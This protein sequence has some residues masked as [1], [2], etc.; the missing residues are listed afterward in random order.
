MNLKPTTEPDVRM[1]NSY[2]RCNVFFFYSQTVLWVRFRKIRLE[3]RFEQQGSL[4]DRLISKWR[5]ASEIVY[6]ITSKKKPCLF[7]EKNGTRTSMCIDWYTAHGVLDDLAVQYTEQTVRAVRRRDVHNARRAVEREQDF[8]PRGTRYRY[9]PGTDG[10]VT[11]FDR[12]AQGAVGRVP[13]VRI[14]VPCVHVD[15]VPGHHLSRVQ[16]VRRRDAYRRAF[17]SVGFRVPFAGG[18]PAARGFAHVPFA[19]FS[20]VLSCPYKQKA[21]RPTVVREPSSENLVGLRTFGP[22]RKQQVFNVDSVRTVSTVPVVNGVYECRAI[23]VKMFFK[24][25]SGSGQCRR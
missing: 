24:H 8:P 1:C 9:G 25:F 13:A 19:P 16:P 21:P 12:R 15:S 3:F 7:K 11:A 6:T 14:R 20:S 5:S 22:Q 17:V 23:G 4:R 10:G 18:R 2:R